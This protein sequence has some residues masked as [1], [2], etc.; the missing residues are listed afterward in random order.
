MAVQMIALKPHRYAGKALVAG[1]EFL[2]GGNTA[3]R[4]L[5]ALG[6]AAVCPPIAP[7]QE[8]V[9]AESPAEDV[10]AKPKRGRPRKKADAPEADAS[11]EVAE[12]TEPES[13]AEQ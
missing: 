2:V 6:R 13:P 1:D 11:P 5:T 7:A 9:P 4:L 3:A 10:E 12:A 8:T